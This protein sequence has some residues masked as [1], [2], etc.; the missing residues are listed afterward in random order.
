MR[1]FEVILIATLF[2]AAVAQI[3]KSAARW[4]KFLTLLAVLAAVW[5]VVHEGTHWQMI[6]ALTGLLLLVAWQL[7]PLSRR[8]SLYAAMKNPVAVIVALLSITTFGML[9]I[10]PMFKLPK[11]TGPYPVGTRIIYLKDSRR[12]ED[13]AKSPET[14]RELIVQ[15]W[16]PADPSNNHLAPYERLSET[17]LATSYRSVLWTNSRKDAPVAT[18][19]GPFP[20]L[21][22]NH[23]WA[24]RR[25]QDTFLTEDLASHGYVVA[26]IDHTYNS[27][28]VVLPGNRVIDNIGGGDPINPSQHSAKEILDT[29]N[30]ELSKWVADEIFVLNTLQADNLDPKSFWYGRLDTNH[31]GALGHSFGGAAAIQ[32]C[33]VDARIQ[34]ALNMDGWTFGD[35]HQRAANQPTMFLYGITSDSAPQDPDTMGPADR[36]GAEL[37]TEDR[38]E[39]NATLQ[40]FGGYKVSISGT[41]HMDFT[42]RPLITPWRRWLKPGD[43]LPARIQ[44][45]VRAY[46]LAF[47]DQTIRKES[48]P[49]LESGT[50]SPFE[51]VKIEHWNPESKAPPVETTVK[52]STR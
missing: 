47:F 37:D 32:V 13:M 1:T 26:S 23:A 27:S 42:D 19:G 12:T 36:I 7:V 16:Y 43:I 31:A 8:T 9:L 30:K 10:V 21:L 34:S 14:P 40:Q 6:P 51:E 52:P 17:I 44:T 39:V 35:I 4:S 18:H 29:W 33:S 24:G 2:A 5:H 48:P 20:V 41:S 11:P 45:I 28:R 38:N 49:L 15:I 22:F 46:V 25:T 3:T 50:S